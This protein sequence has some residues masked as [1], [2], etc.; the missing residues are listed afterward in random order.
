MTA[1]SQGDAVA[2]GTMGLTA[3]T[4]RRLPSYAKELRSTRAAG[5]APNV[6]AFIGRQAWERARTRPAGHRLVVPID[7]EL[8]P[9][10]FDYRD[11]RGLRVVLNAE[12]ADIFIASEVAR[13][14]IVDGAAGV[15]VLHRGIVGG[16]KF[17]RPK[18]KA[19]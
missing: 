10:D 5:I 14:M 16:A 2:R 19:T 12:D 13:Q 1:L 6:F 11:V 7:A 15:V 17:F 9:R 18:A 4:H 3:R 8:G